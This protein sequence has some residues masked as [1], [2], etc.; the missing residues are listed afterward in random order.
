M[1]LQLSSNFH[2]LQIPSGYWRVER[3]VFTSKT[4]CRVYMEL[5]VSQVAANTVP[6][7]SIDSA[8]VDF[9]YDFNSEKSLHHQ[10]Y[11]AAK[12]LSEFAGAIDV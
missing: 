9:D 3:F 10:A 6:V 11:D 5:Y 8:V 7:R 4:Q 12:L 1:A 2:G